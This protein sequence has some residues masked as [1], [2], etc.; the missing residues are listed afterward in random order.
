MLRRAIFFFLGRVP[1]DRG[2][3]KKN[4]RAAQ[5]GQP[6]RF[7]IPLVPANA[8][9]D[10]SALRRPGFET[11]IARSEVELLVESGSSG[12]CILRYFPRSLPSASMIAAVL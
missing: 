6:R 12:M 7:R 10:I 4:L 8:D 1:A 5:R 9:A 2:R 3:I 11:E